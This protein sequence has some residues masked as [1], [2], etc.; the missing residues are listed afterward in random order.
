MKHLLLILSFIV[1][2]NIAF[3]Q[4][5]ETKYF[6]GRYTNSKE[7]TSRK[8]K[9]VRT[10]TT[11]K[12][13]RVETN[14]T[15]IKDNFTIWSQ[16]YLN[17]EPVG[18]WFRYWNNGNLMS[19]LDYDQELNY[20]E[21]QPNDAPYLSLFEKKAKTK[22][23]GNLEFPTLKEYP[24]GFSSY[25]VKNY[26]YPDPAVEKGITGSVMV[27]ISIDEQGKTEVLSILKGAHRYLDLE[28]Y[29]LLNELPTWTPFKINNVPT[30]AYA[31]V[32]IRFRLG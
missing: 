1:S 8:A 24:E 29:R 13:G 17:E 5:I 22:I 10:I 11:H 26:R 19:R 6:K 31:I 21:E 20:S 12:D 27:L 7:T 9:F 25:I 16:T 18:V 3:S 2:Y 14:H 28:A 15:R 30:K 23:D 32:P 4:T